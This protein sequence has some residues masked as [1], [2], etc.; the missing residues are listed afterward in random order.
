M[1]LTVEDAKR[2]QKENR[3]L[4]EAADLDS[5]TIRGLKERVKALESVDSAM[6]KYDIS[7]VAELIASLKTNNEYLKMRVDRFEKEAAIRSKTGKR[8]W[9]FLQTGKLSGFPKLGASCLVLCVDVRDFAEKM[10][11]RTKN[12]AFELKVVDS[13]WRGEDWEKYSIP[14]HHVV[15]A[16]REFPEVKAMH[17]VTDFMAKAVMMLLEDP[18][19]FAKAVCDPSRA[20]M[21]RAGENKYIMKL[22]DKLIK[23]RD[24][25]EQFFE[26][27]VKE[28]GK[29]LMR[30]SS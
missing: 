7:E 17:R 19:V 22:M 8:G 26:Q 13:M 2:L 21:D 18:E 28:L 20:L 6:K 4:K 23:Y 15:V 3:L 27:E 30:R 25:Q 5:Q 12:Q 11:S 14:P 9:N 10:I 16:W 24:K 29:N 1:K